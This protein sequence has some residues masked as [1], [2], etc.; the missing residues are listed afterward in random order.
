MVH[1]RYDFDAGYS[2]LADIAG[3][4]ESWLTA[5]PDYDFNSDGLVD[6]QDWRLLVDFWQVRDDLMRLL[7]KHGFDKLVWFHDRLYDER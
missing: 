1:P 6:L 4:A 7:Q 2:Q 3:F 5:N